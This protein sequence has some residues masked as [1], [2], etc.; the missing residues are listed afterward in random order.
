MNQ[1]K[2]TPGPWKAYKLNDRTFRPGIETSIGYTVVIHGNRETKDI[3]DFAGVFGR[4]SEEETA[5]ARLIAAAPDL[6]RACKAM[7]VTLKQLDASCVVTFDHEI[8][9]LEQAI[10]QAEGEGQ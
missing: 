1:V 7:L 9:I 8:D 6:L 5:N 10:A 3:S 2:Y 4:G